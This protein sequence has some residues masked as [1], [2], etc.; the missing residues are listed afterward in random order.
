MKKWIKIVFLSY[1]WLIW[2]VFLL[3]IST[4][5]RATGGLKNSIKTT[6]PDMVQITNFVKCGF[7]KYIGEGININSSEIFPKQ[8]SPDL[9]DLE[10]ATFF[11]YYACRKINQ[12]FKEPTSFWSLDLG[13]WHFQVFYISIL[14]LK[15]K[16]LWKYVG[17]NPHYSMLLRNSRYAAALYI[18]LNVIFTEQ[19]DITKIYHWSFTSWW[20]FV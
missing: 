2:E 19:Y 5:H 1:F 6:M 3:T 4:S 16:M 8:G 15:L 11:H 12:N 9:L 20:K 14:R 18:I 13:A 7:G 17:L 10:N